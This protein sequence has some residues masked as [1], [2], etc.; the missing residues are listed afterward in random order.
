MVGITGG[1]GVLGKI[2]QSKYKALNQ[3]VCVF[4]G[5]I[6]NKENVNNWLSEN[7][8]TDI[9]H[10]ASKVAVKDVQNNLPN[11]YE[12]NIS[13]TVNL[14]KAI[15]NKQSKVNFFYAS[16]SH[17]YKSSELPLTEND[18]IQPINS[19]GLT[20]YL[21]ELILIDYKKS[22][23]NFN[24]CIGRIFS[25]YHD[26]QQPPFLY[27]NLMLRFQN[28]NL[29][30]PFQLFGALSTRDFLNAEQVCDIILKLVEIKYQGTV[31]IASGT[32]IKIMD[33]VQKIAPQKLTFQY[34][35]TEKQNH[36]NADINLL[37]R[38]LIH[39]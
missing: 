6:T 15:E 23:P 9:I 4:D 29:E 27:P 34:D 19:Y 13:G 10:L 31:N 30:K 14:L 26:S 25:F 32:S 36:L 18:T 39:E 22:N 1:N 7:P 37:N 3:L 12:V 2:L 5:D 33:F 8:I 35:L 21:S 11:A 16:S 38:I 17:V 24:L 20:K 28:E